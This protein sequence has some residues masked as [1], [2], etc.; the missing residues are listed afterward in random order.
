MYIVARWASS[1]PI[2]AASRTVTRGDLVEG[3]EKARQ[4]LILAGRVRNSGL[5]KARDV[6]GKVHLSCLL[7]LTPRGSPVGQHT[8]EIIETALSRPIR[9]IDMSLSSWIAYSTP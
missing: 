6:K 8:R 5:W 2:L 1:A 7:D 4:L 9:R 3:E